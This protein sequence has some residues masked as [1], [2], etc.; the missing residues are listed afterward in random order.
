MIGEREMAYG[1]P[2]VVAASHAIIC[3]D[4]GFLFIRRSLWWISSLDIGPVSLLTLATSLEIDL[5]ERG[6]CSMRTPSLKHLSHAS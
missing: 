6:L 5:G 4:I 1:N 3:L 2:R